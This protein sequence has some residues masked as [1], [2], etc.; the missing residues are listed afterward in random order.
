M[1]FGSYH[2]LRVSSFL[3]KSGMPNWAGLRISYEEGEAV[4]VSGLIPPD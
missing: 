4:L 1:K 2:L 3:N